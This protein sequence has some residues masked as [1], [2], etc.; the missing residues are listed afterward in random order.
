[1]RDARRVRVVHALRLD[2]EAGLAGA[3]LVVRLTPRELDR[4]RVEHHQLLVTPRAHV[5]HERD[6]FGN[7]LACVRFDVA[8]ASIEIE[9]V[10]TVVRAAR[11]D[12]RD[13]AEPALEVLARAGVDVA[14]PRSRTKPGACRALAEDALA[15]LRKAGVVC[16]YVAGY[17]LPSRRA[18]TLPHAWIALEV[19]GH[20]FVEFDPTRAEIEPAHVV[21]AWGD[22]YGDAAPLSGSLFG[23]S[24]DGAAPRFRLTSDVTATPLA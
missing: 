20:G 7:A 13:V 11:G 9:A 16:R 14:S 2:V 24:A 5:T 22:G 8:V 18:S 1:V 6:A 15:R 23:P 12:A 4:Q 3:E 10:S 17:A 21:L 19:G